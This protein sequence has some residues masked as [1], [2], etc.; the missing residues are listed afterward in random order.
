MDELLHNSETLPE[1]E[2]GTA[3]KQALNVARILGWLGDIGKL[4]NDGMLEEITKEKAREIRAVLRS[5][6]WPADAELLELA[7]SEADRP[8]MPAVRG[9][10]G[11]LA[12]LLADDHPGP[13]LG[14]M[15]RWLIEK[16]YYCDLV[17]SFGEAQALAERSDY[18]VLCC[19]L[20]WDG[21][22]LD[23]GGEILRCARTSSLRGAAGPGPWRLRVVCSGRAQPLP[24]IALERLGATHCVSRSLAQLPGRDGALLGQ[25][26]H[27][28][29]YRTWGKE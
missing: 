1:A 7:E 15:R 18:D 5:W 10:G 27:G 17:S 24:S 11:T 12:I 25:I 20:T 28:L 22:A 4:N 14:T 16:G 13:E 6:F 23:A 2:L 3:I 8:A 29:I 21:Y 26:L 9:E 19:D